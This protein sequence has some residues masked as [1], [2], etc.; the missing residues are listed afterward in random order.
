MIFN[1]S[2]QEIFVELYAL[3]EKSKL[4]I[5]DLKSRKDPNLKRKIDCIRFNML[6]KISK[7]LCYLPRYKDNQYKQSLRQK[8][9]DLI[10][11]TNLI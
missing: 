10:D 11:Q 1:Q 4:E 2:P 6:G 5:S 7:M 3:L 9:Q 8:I